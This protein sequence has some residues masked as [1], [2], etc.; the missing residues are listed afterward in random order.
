[1]YLTMF[2][3]RIRFISASRIRFMR[4]IRLDLK[5]DPDLGTFEV[6]SGSVMLFTETDTYQMKRVQNTAGS[7]WKW[8]KCDEFLT[9]RP[10]SFHCPQVNI[11]VFSVELKYPPHKEC[12][13]PRAWGNGS[14]IFNNK[15]KGLFTIFSAFR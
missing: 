5:S 13:I 2:R 4:R 10:P 12:T 9:P 11:V 7:G 8:P 15:L 14:F 3:I 1:M 6:G